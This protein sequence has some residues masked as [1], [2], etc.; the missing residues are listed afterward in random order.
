ARE[1]ALRGTSADK[2]LALAGEV[3]DDGHIPK[4]ALDKIVD[5]LVA[6]TQAGL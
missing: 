3:A 1:I 5:H 4:E 2:Q 6:E